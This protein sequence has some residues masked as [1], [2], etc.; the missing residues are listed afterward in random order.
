MN[1]AERLKKIESYGRAYDQLIIALSCFPRG[2]WQHRSTP[3]RWTIHEIVIHIADSEA[4]SYVRC[5]RLIAEPG[6]TVMAYDEMAWAYKLNYHAQSP[7]A[8]LELFKQLRAASYELIKTLPET[9]W[10]NT[11]VHPDNGVMTMDDWLDIY[12]RHIP[13]HITQM[14]AVYAAWQTQQM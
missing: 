12:N 7:E 11:I 3:D 13:D 8:A 10:A 14:Q 5:R 1:H 2:M 4:N 6:S 9:L